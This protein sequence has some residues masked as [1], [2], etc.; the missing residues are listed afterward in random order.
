MDWNANLKQFLGNATDLVRKGQL[1]DATRAI[2]QALGGAPLRE[3][4]AP[5]AAPAP[6]PAAAPSGP[7]WRNGYAQADVEDATVILD[8]VE[9]AP[10]SAQPPQPAPAHDAEAPGSFRRVAFARAGAPQDHYYL[11]VPPGAS[12]AAGPLP[13]VLM[14]H[15]CTQD[16]EDFATGT[17][18]NHA[19]A[20]ERALVLYPAQSG[21]AN[22]K[23]CWNWFQP[24]D[25][26]RGSGE[27]ATLV[28]MVR[29][30]MARHPVDARRVY[31]AGLS[32]GGA[33]AALLAREYPD[34]FAAAGVHSGLAAGAAQNVMAALSAMKT[35]A[36]PASTSP[37]APVPPIVRLEQ[38]PP[39]IVFHGDADATVHPRNGEQLIEAAL[40]VAPEG[41]VPS[42]STGR[43]AQGQAYTRTVYQGG[44]TTLAEHWVLHGGGHAW[45]GGDARG[46]HTDPRGISATEAMLRFFLAHSRS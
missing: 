33:M 40:A 5:A 9:E 10:P 3:A 20:R 29:E 19:A 31:V 2:Q 16:P 7:S 4:R 26:R 1:A 30:V 12:T 15:G 38:A 34:V 18:M 22:P 13:L 43:S 42:V 46:S 24:Q 23:A 41:A 44:G 14:L 8:R 27:P 35:G 45:A 39:L 25:Q 17:G 11:Y 37:I 6:T 36:K 32:A 21:Q 28:A